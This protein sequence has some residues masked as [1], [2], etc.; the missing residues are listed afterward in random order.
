MIKFRA[1]LKDTGHSIKFDS[2]GQAEVVLVIPTSDLPS[3]IPIVT[4][5]KK[6]LLVGIAEVTGPGDCETNDD[7]MEEWLKS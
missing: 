7:A 6:I 3:F 2:D 4:L 5:G 1:T